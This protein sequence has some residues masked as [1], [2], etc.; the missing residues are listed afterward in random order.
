MFTPKTLDTLDFVIS[1]FRTKVNAPIIICMGKCD[2][3]RDSEQLARTYR[4]M[5]GFAEHG[6]QVCVISG[7]SNYNFEKPFLNLIRKLSHDESITFVE[8]PV[9][10]L[11]TFA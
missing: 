2:V 5:A 10:A 1:S 11:S 3:K 4:K 6:H 9:T 8:Y 7:K